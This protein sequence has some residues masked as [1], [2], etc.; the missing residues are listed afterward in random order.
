MSALTR[1]LVGLMLLID[2]P[3]YE[4]KWATLPERVDQNVEFWLH[5]MEDGRS[6]LRS[7][8]FRATG[9]R[10]DLSID[11]SPFERNLELEYTFDF[12]KDLL[13]IDWH[14]PAKT[15]QLSEDSFDES[16][17]ASIETLTRLGKS[18]IRDRF[19][20]YVRT[21]SYSLH[22][23]SDSERVVFQHEPDNKR[24]LPLSRFD[25]R[26]P[27]LTV[28]RGFED[29]IS[30]DEINKLLL[31]QKIVN[32]IE[33]TANGFARIEWEINHL[34]REIWLD[35]NRGYT[36]IHFTIR[37]RSGS[38]DKPNW[39]GAPI[40]EADLTWEKNGDVWVPK[41]YSHRQQ[42]GQK[43]VSS[44]TIALQWESVNEPVDESLFTYER[45]NT[46]VKAQ[47]VSDQLGQS[48]SVGYAYPDG[49]TPQTEI[50][51]PT[52]VTTR[53]RAIIYANVA[54]VAV[55]AFVVLLKRRMAARSM[56]A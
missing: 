11:S 34:R 45:L 9:H 22:W 26:T 31:D 47:V 43:L 8:R 49:E 16:S 55:L 24:Y 44:F 50:T 54:V 21:Q 19:S 39:Q 27:G 36:P 33:D 38:Q 28:M 10:I 17:Q 30:F 18:R 1:M 56:N 48:V 23:T 32:A 5:G 7:G 3:V 35:Q 15:L 6:R 37:R 42:V 41:T 20:K 40:E 14:E 4:S 25:V 29:G 13:R 51:L 46:P 53:R 12:T 52:D 2:P